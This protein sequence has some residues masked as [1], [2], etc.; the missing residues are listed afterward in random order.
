[1]ESLTSKESSQS[2]KKSNKG[3]IVGAAVGAIVL[4]L[5]F[6]PPYLRQRVTIPVLAALGNRS[7]QCFVHFRDHFKDPYTAYLVEGYELSEDSVLWPSWLE[8]GSTVRR[9]LRIEAK[10]RNG[11]GAY[12]SEYFECGLDEN[13][14]FDEVKTAIIRLD[15]LNSRSY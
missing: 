9:I 12:D 2:P 3:P 13:E 14:R 8:K 6:A 5:L 15:K 4:G 1:M 11:F 10:A 7:A